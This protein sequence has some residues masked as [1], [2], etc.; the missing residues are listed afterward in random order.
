[1]NQTL[2]SGSS[3]NEPYTWATF[4]GKNCF[5]SELRG[6]T[7]DS[8]LGSQAMNMPNLYQPGASGFSPSVLSTLSRSNDSRELELVE[9]V[10]QGYALKYCA[11]K[12]VK[13]DKASETSEDFAKQ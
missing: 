8:K 6:I 12:D 1:M 5:I 13:A 4:T 3:E 11:N 2:E 9:I 10:F 7:G